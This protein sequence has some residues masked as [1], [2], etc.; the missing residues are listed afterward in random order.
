MQQV[1]YH[2]AK[3]GLMAY[4]QDGTLNL[5]PLRHMQ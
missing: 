5:W 1:R 3:T 4:Q 2:P